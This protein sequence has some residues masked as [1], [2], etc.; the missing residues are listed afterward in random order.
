V[1]T[2]T[3]N[4]AETI[5]PPQHRHQPCLALFPGAGAVAADLEHL[6]AGQ[7]LGGSR[8]ELVTSARR[9]GIEYIRPRMPPGAHK[10]NDIQNGNPVHHPIM[11]IP[12]STR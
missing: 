4:A 12:G 8:S 6:G 1:A 9:N 5:E 7:A 3:A 11:I 10:A 2:T